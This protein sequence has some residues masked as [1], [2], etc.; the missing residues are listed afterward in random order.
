MII[1]PAIDLKDGKCVRLLKG[2]EGTETVFS[3]NPVET[4][5]KWENCGAK[6]IHIVDLDGAFEGVAVNSDIIIDIVRNVNCNIQLGGGIRNMETADH[7]MS[8]GV[9]RLIIGTKAFSDEEFITEICS[10]YP[11]RISVGL[12]TK[13]NR[14]AVK[15]WKEVLDLS[16]DDV[17]RKLE[18]NGASM[19][20]HT[21]VDKDGTMEG[22]N[23]EPIE[24]FI[25]NCSVPV[26]ASGGIA[27]MND[28]E[29]LSVLTGEGLYGVILGKSI[30]SGSIDLKEAINR[31]K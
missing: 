21:N 19:F 3:L 5:L 13:N 8:A 12:D 31:Y 18:K 23:I 28:L 29:N 20:V 6:W 16:I 17:I 25:K 2:E 24:K 15:G 14:I 30:Y 22:I 26:I 27:S 4:A 9:Q 1:I 10:K 11:G 7:Y